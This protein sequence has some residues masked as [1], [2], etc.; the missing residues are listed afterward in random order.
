MPASG[1]QMPTTRDQ[2]SVDML[3]LSAGTDAATQR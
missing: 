1:N 2:D 3:R